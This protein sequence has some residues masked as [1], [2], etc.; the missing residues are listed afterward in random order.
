VGG[1]GLHIE[2]GVFVAELEREEQ[3]DKGDPD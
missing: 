3:I 2:N 1:H